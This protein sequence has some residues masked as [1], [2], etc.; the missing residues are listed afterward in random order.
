MLHII[1]VLLLNFY[2]LYLP[3]YTHGPL[4]QVIPTLMIANILLSSR[5]YNFAIRYVFYNFYLEKYK[6]CQFVKMGP[7]DSNSNLLLQ[8]N[9]KANISDVPIHMPSSH[10]TSLKIVGDV[11]IL[12]L[13]FM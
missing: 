7:K 1:I 8:L 11:N 5:P 13:M 12:H 9:L 3:D 6:L 4:L 10:H 2:S